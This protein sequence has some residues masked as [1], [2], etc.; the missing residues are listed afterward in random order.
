[1]GKHRIRAFQSALQSAVRP[2][3]VVV[4]IGA[5]VGTY[6]FFAAR[7]GAKRVYAIEKARVI[8][9]AEGLAA[10]NGLAEKITFVAGD[11]MEVVLPEKGDFLVLEHFS[12]L[13]VRRGIEELMH[14]ALERHLKEGCRIMPQAVSLFMAPIG[15][16]KLWKTCLTLEDDNY[17]LCGLDLSLLRQ[18]M[19]DSPHVRAIEPQAL[20]AE[21]QTFKT[22]NLKQSES[23]L[24]DEVLAV[25][26]DRS[27]TMYGIAGWFD[28]QLTETLV[29]SNGP[30]NPDSTWAQVFFPFSNPLSVTQGETVTLRL[31]CTRSAHTRDIWWTWQASASSGLADNRSFQGVPLPRGSLRSHD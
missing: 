26:I 11:S 15:D 23:Y 28:L 29:L 10:R 5:G 30:S 21:P 14:D 3:D 19:L 16:E 20:L 7:S 6:S 12:S 27:G 31:S 8:Q 2:G 22:I 17:L 1:M 24:F 4:E 18:M 25:R 13:F 9:V